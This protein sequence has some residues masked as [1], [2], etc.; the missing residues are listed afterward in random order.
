[1]CFCLVN[2]EGV[3]S[4]VI[5][6]YRY[7][8]H[9]FNNRNFCSDKVCLF[10]C[11]PSYSN[12]ESSCSNKN[13]KTQNILYF[14]VCCLDFFMLFLLSYVA[15][16]CPSPFLEINTSPSGNQHTAKSKKR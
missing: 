6:I 3:D 5:Y 13:R 7:C 2:V 16:I 12:G 1:M 4:I 15:Q 10:A 14:Y 8:R 11:L 9:V